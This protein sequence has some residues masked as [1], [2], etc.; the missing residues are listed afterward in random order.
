LK[1]A[2]LIVIP[3][4]TPAPLTGMDRGDPDA[5][6]VTDRVPE[7]FPAVVGANLT[8]SVTW[9]EGFTVAGVVK[10][11]TENPVPVT[12]TPEICTELV[13]VFVTTTC[14]IKLLPVETFPKLKPVWLAWRVPVGA[15][16]PVPLKV[17]VTFGLVVSELF[18]ERLPAA[19]PVALGV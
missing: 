1:L 6:L 10:P 12:P 11:L 5:L 14:F 2:G 15:V 17:T 19:A 18:I 13:P 8:D 9:L 7:A 4:C 3:G 16:V